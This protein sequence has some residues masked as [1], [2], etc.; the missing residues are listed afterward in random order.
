MKAALKLLGGTMITLAIIAGIMAYFVTKEG[1]GR[2]L[3]EGLGRELGPTPAF[4]RV[5]LG[6]DRMWA[7]W[8]WAAGD[9]I[10]AVTVCGAGYALFIYGDRR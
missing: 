2:V 7:G 5:F 6:Q 9:L 10:I 3:Y 1:R 8:G 4:A